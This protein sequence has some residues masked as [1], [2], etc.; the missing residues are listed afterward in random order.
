MRPSGEGPAVGSYSRAS[1]TGRL[2]LADEG[3]RVR[4]RR[5]VSRRYTVSRDRVVCRRLRAVRTCWTA[6]QRR[7]VAS[8]DAIITVQVLP[9][10]TAYGSADVNFFFATR[11]PR[12][13]RARERVAVYYLALLLQLAH[14]PNVRFVNTG[15]LYIYI[16]IF[17]RIYNTRDVPR[18]II[19]P[20]IL[21]H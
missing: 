20:I 17:V 15:L 18:I 6:G 16:Y 3:S 4:D 19:N 12:L 9:A 10:A 5:V 13:S 2:R 14:N 11:R 8:P 21:I 7:V 1:L